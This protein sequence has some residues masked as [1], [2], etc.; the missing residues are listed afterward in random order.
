MGKFHVY[1]GN[2]HLVIVVPPIL[3]GEW[4]MAYMYMYMYLLKENVEYYYWSCCIVVKAV[5]TLRS[6]VLPVL[7][8]AR[9]PSSPCYEELGS[10]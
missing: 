9:P 7:P 8:P 10:L 3:V 2:V 1:S 6:T 4:S 5:G